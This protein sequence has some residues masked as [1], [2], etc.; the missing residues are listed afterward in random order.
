MARDPLRRIRKIFGISENNST[1]IRN[2]FLMHATIRN[3]ESQSIY[4]FESRKIN[5]RNG[6]IFLLVFSATSSGREAREHTNF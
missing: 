6:L 5:A 3:I 4:L 1:P 2:C